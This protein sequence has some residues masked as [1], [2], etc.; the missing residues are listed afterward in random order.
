MGLKISCKLA[1]VVTCLVPPYR[2]CRTSA[3]PG[4][5]DGHGSTWLRS[6]GHDGRPS[7]RSIVSRAMR[8]LRTAIKKAMITVRKIMKVWHFFGPRVRH[9]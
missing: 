6:S 5:D 7:S 1:M 3:A 8:S 4:T 2:R 9:Y